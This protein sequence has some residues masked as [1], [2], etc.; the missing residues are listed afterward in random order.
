MVYFEAKCTEGNDSEQ[1]RG[2]PISKCGWGMRKKA[3][4]APVEERQRRKSP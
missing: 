2:L 3:T 4:K 1:A